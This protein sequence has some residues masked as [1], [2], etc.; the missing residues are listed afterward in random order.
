MK[1]T[2]F[3][4][5][6]LLPNQHGAFVMAFL[7]YCYAIFA[8][9]WVFAHFW[10]GLTW[11]FLYLFSYPFFALFSKTNTKNYQKWATL[12]A[13]IATLF[14]LPLIFT[15]FAIMQ[16]LLPILPLVGVQIYYAKQKDERN[17]INDIAGI[18]TFGLVGM[19]SYYLATAEYNWAILL[20]PT[21]F[22]IATTLYIKSVARERKNPRYLTFS[23][24]LHCALCLCYLLFG[25][26]LIAFAYAVAFARAFILP[27]KRWN[28][29]QIGL[30]E[31]LISLIFLLCLVFN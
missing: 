26:F 9:H 18:L 14:A 8:S 11:L 10:L 1:V 22:F 30:F 27:K 29:K 16:F 20:H 6:P 7:P 28:I 15:H 5:K 2:L 25:D 3:N 31:F 23:L 24:T 21:L 19:A 4:Q 13:I 12:Y 17:L